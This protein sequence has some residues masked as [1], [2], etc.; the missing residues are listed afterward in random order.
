[1]LEKNTNRKVLNAGISSFATVREMILLNRLDT[2][3]L[4][5]LI[6][7]EFILNACKHEHVP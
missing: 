7:Q 5:Y 4:K 2:S 6:I 1:V 3:N